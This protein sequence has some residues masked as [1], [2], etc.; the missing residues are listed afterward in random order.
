MSFEMTEKTRQLIIR[1]SLVLAALII[2]ILLFLI[3]PLH[4]VIFPNLG[5]PDVAIEEDSGVIFD[6]IDE[7]N[8]SVRADEAIDGSE[9]SDP[10]IEGED[11]EREGTER[12]DEDDPGDDSRDDER[13]INAA[14]EIIFA[15]VNDAEE[16]INFDETITITHGSAAYP[17]LVLARDVDDDPIDFDLAVSHGSIAGITYPEPDRIFFIWQFHGLIYEP[18]DV[19]ITVTARDPAGDSDRKAI[20]IALVPGLGGSEVVPGEPVEPVDPGGAFSVVQTYRVSAVVAQSGYV[21]SAGEVRTGTIIVGD[22]NLNRQYKGYLTFSLERM[23]RIAADDVTGA[24]IVFN[25]VNKSGSPQT[26]GEFVD[27]K[28]FNYG[29]TLDSSDFAVGGNRIVMISTGSFTS[30]S[31]ARGS[32]MSKLRSILSAGDTTL[33]IKI[34]LDEVTNSNNAWDMFQFNP[35]NVEL[36]VDYLE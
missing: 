11:T 1:L 13:H 23:A 28:V 17:I 24:K 20:K 18:L 36:V 21:N 2:L 22:D 29:A 30:G 25:H 35:S 6:E 33:Q 5:V 8:D 15:V 12:E 26:I 3:S 7:E 14:P 34:G 32:L 9:E 27:L 4:E 31:T 19:R 16:V 10:D